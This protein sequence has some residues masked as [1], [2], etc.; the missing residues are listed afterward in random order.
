MEDIQKELI[1]KL[2]SSNLSKYPVSLFHGKMGLSGYF[3]HLSQIESNPAYHSKAEQLLD[4]IMQH[5]LTPNHSIDVEDG[6]AG[7]G[8]G[9]TWLVKRQFI[10][11]DLN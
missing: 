7:I 11:G 10:E 1:D 6:L 2:L 3:Y 8:L 4:Q 9:V 5:D